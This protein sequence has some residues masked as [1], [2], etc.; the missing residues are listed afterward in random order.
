MCTASQDD[1]G[2]GKGRGLVCI[3]PW[4]TIWEARQMSVKEATQDWNYNVINDMDLIIRWQHARCRMK[5]NAPII[6]SPRRRKSG[7]CKR[8]VYI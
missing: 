3:L 1:K 4:I 5:V 6:A 8:I 7:V 2:M